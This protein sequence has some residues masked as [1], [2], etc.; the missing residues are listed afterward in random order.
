ME[1]TTGFAF[2]R[3]CPRLLAAGGWPLEVALGQAL[4]A[5]WP[6]PSTGRLWFIR[7][8]RRSRSTGRLWFIRRIRRSR[9]FG[10]RSLRTLGTARSRAG[11]FGFGDEHQ[12]AVGC[13]DLQPGRVLAQQR[14]VE[15]ASQ[16][17]ISSA[18]EGAGFNP[19]SV[20]AYECDPVSLAIR[21]SEEH[22]SELQSRQYLVCRLLLD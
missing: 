1:I 16:R 15:R 20:L 6:A 7:R 12:L 8:I 2:F 13:A 18:E 5:G 3:R 9:T 17:L 19:F 11:L 22:T 21:R 14:S 10:A 4:L